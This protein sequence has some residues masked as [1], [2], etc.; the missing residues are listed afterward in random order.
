VTAGE[1]GIV[2]LLAIFAVTTAATGQKNPQQ[3]N[4]AA[5]RFS[6]IRLAD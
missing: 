6:Q 4:F 3:I 2:L 1:T 5:D